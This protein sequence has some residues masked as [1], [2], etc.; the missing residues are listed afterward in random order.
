MLSATLRSYVLFTAVR[1]SFSIKVPVPCLKSH[2]VLYHPIA[3]DRPTG[4]TLDVRYG[5]IQYPFVSGGFFQ[6]MM[7]VSHLAAIILALSVQRAS[8]V[9]DSFACQANDF[10]DYGAFA[11][12]PRQ[13]APIPCPTLACTLGIGE[14]Q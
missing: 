6:R 12:H 2:T 11:P 7:S 1:P 13:L 9:H 4:T 14:S 3:T 8:A 5:M 10:Y